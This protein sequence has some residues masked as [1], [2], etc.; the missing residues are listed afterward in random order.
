MTPTFR[1]FVATALADCAHAQPQ[2]DPLEALG[3]INTEVEDPW[4][5]ELLDRAQQLIALPK[6]GD[7]PGTRNNLVLAAA[8]VLAAILATTREPQ[9][10]SDGP[11]VVLLRGVLATLTALTTPEHKNQT[12]LLV[13]VL[14]APT[15]HLTL[16][17]RPTR[18]RAQRLD[19]VK[20]AKLG[21]AIRPECQAAVMRRTR[22]ARFSHSGS[23]SGSAG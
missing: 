19:G 12:V 5:R 15:H 2:D 4:V 8:L 14:P 10:E 16:T 17:G 7:D 20:A 9:G 22:P 23:S 21:Y 13:R 11:H 3:R 6:S 18:C 1:T